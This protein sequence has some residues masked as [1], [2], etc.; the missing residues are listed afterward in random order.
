MPLFAGD[1]TK[2]VISMRGQLE[3]AYNRGLK[4]YQDT[5]CYCYEQCEKYF[6]NPKC[7]FISDEEFIFMK[8]N[9]LINTVFK[10]K[11]NEQL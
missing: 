8:Q 7:L 5:L 2:H 9:G 6:I 10:I 4:E 3:F 11:R 1:I